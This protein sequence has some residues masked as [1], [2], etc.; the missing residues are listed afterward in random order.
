M[1][2]LYCIGVSCV[3]LAL[4]GALIGLF[5]SGRLFT[6]VNFMTSIVG[7]P[8]YSLSEQQLTVH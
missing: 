7:S 5:A 1:F 2:L 6:V 8:K 4:V 3:G